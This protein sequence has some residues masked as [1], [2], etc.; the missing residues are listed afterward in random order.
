MNKIKKTSNSSPNKQKKDYEDLKKKYVDL[1]SYCDKAD[2]EI[3]KLKLV[4][5]YF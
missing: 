4:F 3:T 2:L 5:F 1:Q